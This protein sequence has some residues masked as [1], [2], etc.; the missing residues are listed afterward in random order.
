MAFGDVWA[1]PEMLAV[2]GDGRREKADAELR[3]GDCY[4]SGRS[5][6]DDWEEEED[7]AVFLSANSFAA[8]EESHYITTHEMVLAELSDRECDL[9]GEAEDGGPAGAAETDPPNWA[10]SRRLRSQIQLSIRTTSRAIN[11]PGPAP[12]GGDVHP[13]ASPSGD[14]GLHTGRRWGVLLKDAVERSSGTSS[15]LSEPDDA[16]K[17]VNTLTAKT[18]KSLTR[19]R[20]DPVHSGVSSEFSYGRMSGK[21]DETAVAHRGASGVEP[22]GTPGQVSTLTENLSLHYSVGVGETRGQ[23]VPG[24]GLAEDAGKK[25]TF[26]SSL[27]QNV[28]SKKIQFEQERKMERGEISEGRAKPRQS[29]KASR[30]SS[31][32]TPANAPEEVEEE[33]DPGDGSGAEPRPEPD[34]G[35]GV[36]A[37][38]GR[39]EASCR[40]LPR[41]RNSAFRRW[42]VEEAERSDGDGPGRTPTKMSHLFV[43]SIQAVKSRS[44]ELQINLWSVR[45]DSAGPVARRRGESTD[46]VPH[47]TVRDFRDTKA[48]TQTPMH[49]VR[50]VRK[51]VKSSYHF[52]SLDGPLPDVRRQSAVQRPYAMSP[53]VI[54]CQSVNTKQPESRAEMV[55]K[56]TASRVA[57]EK[58]QAA[59][60]TME[61]LYVFEENEWRRKTGPPAPPAEGGTPLRRDALLGA[62]T[63]SVKTSVPKPY[64]TKA[65]AN[66]GARAEG[67]EM[68]H[69]ESDHEDYLAVS[70]KSQASFHP[71][72]SPGT[73]ELQASQVASVPPTGVGSP[74][75]PLAAVYHGS[76][77]LFCFSPT[78]AAPPALERKVLLDPTTGSCY[79]VDSPVQP[80]TRRLYDP[81][82]GQYVDVAVPPPPPTPVPVSVPPL[83]L[84]LGPYAPAYVIYPGLAPAP[85]VISAQALVAESAKTSLYRDAPFHVATGRCPQPPAQAGPSLP[86]QP[87]ISISS[88]QGPRIIAPPSFDGT[89]MSFVVEHR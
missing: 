18:F 32:R 84:G 58:L 8:D 7:V 13:R 35:A 45:S 61:R 10:E 23:T 28:L 81:E 67:S 41:S 38:K 42:R 64:G 14:A 63:R 53:M 16:N 74:E 89:T 79:L 72:S 66:R 82:T 47:F 49:Q 12:R 48:K 5:N 34:R 78:I 62:Q 69:R 39:V 9:D 21:P 75:A 65:E 6:W 71:R 88:Q 33:E 86:L 80:S 37:E 57:L 40:A 68:P 3:G 11:G 70:V 4:W 29:Y 56:Q 87:I 1:P 51:L 27:I 19:P 83:V 52:V 36:E 55:L 60:R 17:E 26:A 54:K 2:G 85:S 43:P 46:R 44:P 20:F 24:R 73:R 30:S 59:V 25:A 15:A 77:H 22:T 76:P 50:D 31:G